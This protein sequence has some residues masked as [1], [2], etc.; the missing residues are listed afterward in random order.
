LGAATTVARLRWCDIMLSKA[1]KRRDEA[2]KTYGESQPRRHPTRRSVKRLQ[3]SDGA[4]SPATTYDAVWI[5]TPD[6]WHAAAA[7]AAMKIRQG[8]LLRKSR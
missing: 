8:R 3:Y 6:H 5:C 4:A 1:T 2:E 7:N